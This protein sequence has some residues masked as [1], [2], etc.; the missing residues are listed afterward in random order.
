MNTVIFDLDGTITDPSEGIT[1][2]INH[3]LV[4]LGHAA[5]PER[6]LQKY[7]GPNLNITFSEL[8]KT[9]NVA[10]LAHAIELYRERYIPIGYQKNRLYD[11]IHKVLSRLITGGS[12]L[13]I[14]TTKRKDIAVEVLEFLGVETFF[15][16]VEWLRP[17]QVKV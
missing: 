5:H 10:K 14:A 16:Q 4:E 2:S 12:F 15:T 13:C 8:M 3:A 6:D 17:S 9:A 7:I 1:R 11:G